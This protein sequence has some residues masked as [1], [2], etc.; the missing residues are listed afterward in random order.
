GRRRPCH[1][2]SGTTGKAPAG[3]W[4]VIPKGSAASRRRREPPTAREHRNPPEPACA[5]PAPVRCPADTAVS[6][7][8]HRTPVHGHRPPHP[9]C[10]SPPPP[11]PPHARH[12]AGLPQG[13]RLG[14]RPP[15]SRRA[16]AV[17][18]AAAF[19]AGPALAAVPAT[20]AP[21]ADG[22]LAVQYRTSAT[23]ATA[24]Q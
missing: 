2:R 8:R 14:T 4:S 16:R 5:R 10:P 22:A 7:H 6:P 24:D 1:V 18:A 21:A 20:A 15:A 12:R 11:P 13:P 19:R 3:N 9:P 17:P 23:G